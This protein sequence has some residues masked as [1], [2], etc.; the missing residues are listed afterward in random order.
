MFF[1]SLHDLHLT[2]QQ[3]GVLR[4]ARLVYRQFRYSN[5]YNVPL[6]APPGIMT[7]WR[8]NVILREW[9][10][11]GLNFMTPFLSRRRRHGT[12]IPKVDRVQSHPRL[13]TGI[14]STGIW[15]TRR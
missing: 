6:Q 4:D 3:E 9:H 10:I 7:Y 8:A 5:I 13:T 2:C 15:S 11:L 14:W 1:Y 12:T